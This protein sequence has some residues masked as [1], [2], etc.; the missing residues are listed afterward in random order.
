MFACMQYLKYINIVIYVL[1]LCMLHSLDYNQWINQSINQ[2]MEPA[3]KRATLEI[4]KKHKYYQYSKK[5]IIQVS[6]ATI[7]SSVLLKLLKTLI[8][9]DSCFINKH[10]I[11]DELQFRSARNI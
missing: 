9:G 4:L 10:K 8:T 2:S 5:K 7:L 1:L 3:D 6:K 11:L